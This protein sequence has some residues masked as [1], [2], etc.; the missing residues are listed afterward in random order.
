MTPNP[1]NIQNM[2]E[3]IHKAYKQLTFRYKNKNILKNILVLIS[4]YLGTYDKYKVWSEN[5]PINLDFR[6]F[7][8]M[9]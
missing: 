5:I 7:S 6:G 9:V 1:M 2:I 3:V 8:I 4:T